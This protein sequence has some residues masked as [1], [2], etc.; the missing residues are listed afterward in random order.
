MEQVGEGGGEL[1]L[2]LQVESEKLLACTELFWTKQILLVVGGR[3]PQIDLLIYS[4]AR[5]GPLPVLLSITSFEGKE[6][7]KKERNNN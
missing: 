5:T 1:K 7:E 2:P 6:K 3:P 4:M